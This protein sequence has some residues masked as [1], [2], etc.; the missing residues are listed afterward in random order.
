MLG[1][2][3]HLEI[4]C[5]MS[6]QFG[7]FG[8]SS[9]AIH[10]DV[11]ENPTNPAF[12]RAK[13]EGVQSKVAGTRRAALGTITN[14]TRIQPLRAAK[15][16]TGDCK[17]TNIALD[18][19]PF[20]IHVDDEPSM[21]PCAPSATQV[22]SSEVFAVGSEPRLQLSSAVT[23]IRPT[24]STVSHPTAM[25]DESI[26]S[27]DSPMLLDSS[28]QIQARVEEDPEDLAKTRF[29][30]IIGVPEY[31]AE[32]YAYLR[33]AE[34][35]NRPRVNY[36]KK[37]P[38]ITLSMRCILVD[39]LVEVAEEYKL[40]R[41]TLFLAVNYIDR[42][43]SQMSVLRGKLQLVGAASMFLASKYEEIYP[44]EV[45]EFVY[46]TD[47]TYKSKQLLRMEH[48]ILKVLSFDVAVPTINCFC[49]KFAKESGCDDKTLSLAMYLAELTLVEGDPF[50][51]Y[52]PSVTAAA[53]LCLSRHTQG[54]EA[55][56]ESLACLSGYS[57]Q[58]LSECLHD[59][60]TLFCRSLSS[61]QQ[62]IREKYK[63]SKYQMVST[64][65]PPMDLPVGTLPRLSGELPH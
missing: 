25:L 49:E 30:Q 26:Q 40:H 3:E 44:P 35:R 63:Q 53:A 55:W 36:M 47:D 2:V 9:I 14:T 65:S 24:L 61:P 57:V 1:D 32:I 50:I 20:F 6:H 59:L 11:A 7:G 58:D 4:R 23:S 41:E 18:G 19:K 13:M 64:L 48:L 29:E 46:I 22:S 12:K 62:A 8:G 60:H 17:G 31:S 28:P 56:P 42:F 54:L 16:T 15:G 34:L 51:K 43:L 39:W 21:G 52:V 10:S 45:G 5:N 38:D 27:M 33:E 37:Q